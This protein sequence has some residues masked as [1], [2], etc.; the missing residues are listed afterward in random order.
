MLQIIG[1]KIYKLKRILSM[2][3]VPK[4]KEN[5]IIESKTYLHVL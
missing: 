3:D 1:T 4:I 5:M 2:R